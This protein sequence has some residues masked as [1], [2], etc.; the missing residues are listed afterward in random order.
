MIEELKNTAVKVENEQ[1]ARCVVALYEL[2]GIGNDY[3]WKYTSYKNAIGKLVGN[4]E[5]LGYEILWGTLSSSKQITLNQLVWGYGL[6]PEW[7]DVLDFYEGDVYYSGKEKS[8]K[9][10]SE[11]INKFESNKDYMDYLGEIISTRPQAKHSTKSQWDGKGLPPVGCEVQTSTGQVIVVAIKYND[12]VIDD[13]NYIRVVC[14]DAVRPIKT[15]RDEF[16]EKARN[17]AGECY[18]YDLDDYFH[19][20]YDAGARFND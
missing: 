2:A 18:G 15:E 9:I 12:V 1:Q 16:I 5:S 8:S 6:A 10:G 13:G 3:G 7:A 19:K 17:A 4:T 20:L 14:P 11:H